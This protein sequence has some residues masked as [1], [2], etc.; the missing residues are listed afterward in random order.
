MTRVLCATA[1]ALALA[2]PVA[3]QTADPA[4]CQKQV[5]KQLAKFKKT[6]LKALEK[7]LD[8]ENEGKITGTFP[9][10]PDAG[11]S[12]K[13][14]KVTVAVPQQIA[15]KCDMAALAALGFRTDCQYEAASA[16]IEGQCFGLPVTTPAEFGSC[17]LCWK[18]AELAEF[19][20]ILYA[21]H[22]GEVCRNDLAETSSV[23]SDLECTTP[24]P[25]QRDL[26]GP[27][28]GGEEFCQKGIGKAGI[29]YLLDREKILEKCALKF[30]T[31]TKA[32]CLAGTVDPN[33]P[34]KLQKA[35]LKKATTIKKFC[36]NR[37]PQP[38]PPFCCRTGTGNS[39]VAATSRDD[40]TMN[41]G[42]NVQEGKTCN[43][44]N[45]DPSPGNKKITWWGVCP[46]SDCTGTLTTLDDLTACVD[47]SADAVVDELLCLQF[48][49]NGGADWPCPVDTEATT[50]TTSTTTSTTATIP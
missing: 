37:D 45:C 28:S 44:G 1:I 27:G 8:Q 5:A 12:F 26:S 49:R 4:Q 35:E 31:S 33:V 18:G 30:A 40:C 22:A 9:V 15:K 3:A 16:G 47:T 24:L 25:D 21:S 36:G 50:T 19:T 39:C 10:C 23:C 17:L 2:A 13:I 14:Q 46:E 29:K 42:G 7:C 43:A 11:A 48:P 20:V 6:Y 41:L 32:T 38:S 34:L